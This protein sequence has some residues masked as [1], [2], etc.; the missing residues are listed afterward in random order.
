[1]YISHQSMTFNTLATPPQCF[2]L[3]HVHV[4]CKNIKVVLT[5]SSIPKVWTV[6]SPLFSDPIGLLVIAVRRPKF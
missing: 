1:M 6:T 3:T 5:K 2:T 4:H